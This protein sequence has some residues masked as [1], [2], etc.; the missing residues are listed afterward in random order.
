MNDPTA[1]DPPTNLIRDD[2]NTNLTKI[3]FSWTP[4]VNNGGSP[5]TGYQ[6][7][8]LIGGEWSL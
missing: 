6:I 2:A 5:V 1:P 8:W 3:A 7:W 4:P